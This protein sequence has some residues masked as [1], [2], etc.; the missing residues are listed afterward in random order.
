MAITPG[1]DKEPVGCLR[2][3]RLL[4]P[5]SRHFCG[6]IALNC[7]HYQPITAILYTSRTGTVAS[8]IQADSRIASE[9]VEGDA[10][11]AGASRDQTAADIE[12][13]HCGREVRAMDVPE[14]EELT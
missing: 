11:P 4:G 7:C 5:G 13:S 8:V 1:S 6:I 12:R 14:P 3:R 10:R 2:Y 9:E